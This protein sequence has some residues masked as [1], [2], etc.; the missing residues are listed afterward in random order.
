MDPFVARN[1]SMG[2]L[3]AV[4][5]TSGVMVGVASAGMSIH[6]ILLTGFILV[7]VEATSMA[8]SA[9]V[10]D[11]HFQLSSQDSENSTTT[12]WRSAGWMLAAYMVTGMLLLLPYVL[13]R[14]P[15]MASS[16]AF[17]LALTLMFV[18]VHRFQGTRAAV[19]A[20]AIGAAVMVTSILIGQRFGT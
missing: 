4:I 15:A 11:R 7:F 19:Q 13:A 9:A 1:V 5:S 6:H 14:D 8:Y 3:D 16:C 17:I 10:S 18:I 20:S 12:P 2:V